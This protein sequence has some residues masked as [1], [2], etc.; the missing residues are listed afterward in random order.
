VVCDNS[1]S[2]RA[3]LSL[4]DELIARLTDTITKY[5]LNV[6]FVLDGDATPLLDR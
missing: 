1:T 2:A 3:W 6:E 4:V 5:N